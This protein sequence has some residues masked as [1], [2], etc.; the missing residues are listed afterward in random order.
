M[1]QVGATG[2]R[3]RKRD[4]C[5]NTAASQKQLKDTVSLIKDMSGNNTPVTDLCTALIKQFYDQ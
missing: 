2:K 1:L 4:S 3:Y 5:Y